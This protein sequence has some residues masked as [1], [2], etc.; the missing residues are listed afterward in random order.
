MSIYLS[1]AYLAPVQYY[2]CLL[3]SEKVFIEA[4]EN[5]VKQSYRTRCHIAAANGVL[6]L[7]IPVDKGK[8]AK[9][10]IR[11]VRIDYSENW[12]QQHWRS[13]ESAYRSSPFLEYYEDDLRPFYETHREF[14]F[15]FNLEI[16]ERILSL[17]GISVTI[18]LT[19]NYKTCFAPGEV[20]L[21]NAI[22]PKKTD[23]ESHFVTQPY[24]Q[25]FEQK[26]GF[27][28]DLSIIDL[29]FNMGNEARLILKK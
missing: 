21:R 7:S 17:L 12:Q 13:I 25:V 5:Y 20:D 6:A 9:C 19:D 1:T 23:S 28:P 15:D 3:H 24:Y 16:Q 14:L 4:H 27:L 18:S 26:F 10:P 2:T 29:L 11:D 8:A 22:S